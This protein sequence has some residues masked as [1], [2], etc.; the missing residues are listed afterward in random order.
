MDRADKLSDS[1]LPNQVSSSSSIRGVMGIVPSIKQR[2][3][4]PLLARG[5]AGDGQ[6]RGVT[7]GQR[8]ISMEVSHGLSCTMR[9]PGTNSANE[10]K[11][12]R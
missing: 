3:D 11:L 10:I 8:G 2:P 5:A 1:L 4:D 9:K 7:V 6:F 12:P